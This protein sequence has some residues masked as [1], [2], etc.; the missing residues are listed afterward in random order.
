MMNIRDKVNLNHS[1]EPI[2]AHC[3]NICS[4]ATRVH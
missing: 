4:R 3:E 2:E 1:T